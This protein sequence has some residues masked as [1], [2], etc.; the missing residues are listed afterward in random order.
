MFKLATRHSPLA[1]RYKSAFTL[2]E[3]SLVIVI[4]GLVVGGVLVGRDLIKA[5]EIRAQISQIEQIETAYNTFKIKYNCFPGDCPNATDFFGTTDA[6]GNT[7]QNGNNDSFISG[8]P[9]YDVSTCVGYGIAKE[10]SQLFLHLNNAGLGK[11]AANGNASGVTAIVGREFPYT[12][13]GNGTGVYVTCLTNLGWPSMTPAFLYNG[14][15]I[16]I[17]SGSGGTTNGSICTNMGDCGVIIN[18]VYGS[19]NVL[20]TTTNST[21]AGLPIDV[22][23]QIDLK[24]DDGIPNKGKFGVAATEII[25]GAMNVTAYPSPSSR[26]LATGGKLIR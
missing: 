22:L 16:V 5:A 11:Y 7:V 6:N 9:S 17:G 21:R 18:G 12:A 2:I 8:S 26:C 13:F 4:I 1:T 19:D 14:N 10:V 20:G 3:L 15:S 25:C 24:I 23:R